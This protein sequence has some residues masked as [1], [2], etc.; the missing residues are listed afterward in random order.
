MGWFSNETYH[1]YR[2]VQHCWNHLQIKNHFRG[3]LN[4]L[5]LES[6]SLPRSPCWNELVRL[7]WHHKS[8]TNENNAWDGVIL[9]HGHVFIICI[10]YSRWHR[11]SNISAVWTGRNWQIRCCWKMIWF[12]VFIFKVLTLSKEQVNTCKSLNS[13][14]S[15][16]WTRYLKHLIEGLRWSPVH[17]DNVWFSYY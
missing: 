8:P 6:S 5:R 17:A 16:F 2:R 4:F 9:R 15:G 13:D 12:D 14:V 7:R 3:L 11:K 10:I 1:L